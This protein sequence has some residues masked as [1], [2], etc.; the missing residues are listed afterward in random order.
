MRAR[1]WTLLLA[2]VLGLALGFL[3]RGTGVEAFDV[4]S[5]LAWLAALAAAVGLLPWSRVLPPVPPM[6]GLFDRV[7]E[8][9]RWCVH[10][11]S[12]TAR[13]GPCVVCKAAGPPAPTASKA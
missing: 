3:G 1:A 8:G 5:G 6:P 12:P 2:V 11:G 4:L 7:H 9:Q 10:C 13:E